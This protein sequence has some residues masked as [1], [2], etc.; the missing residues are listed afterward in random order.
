MIYDNSQSLATPI[1][2]FVIA[3]ADMYYSEQNRRIV[4]VQD[5]PESGFHIWGE[6]PDIGSV[7][8]VNLCELVLEYALTCRA[9]GDLSVAQYNMGAFAQKL[10]QALANYLIDRIPDELENACVC[11]MECVIESMKVGFA[12]EQV[13][14]ELRFVL[15]ECPLHETAIRTGFTGEDLA[16]Y[17]IQVLCETLVQAFDPRLSISIPLEEDV[18][19]VFTITL[20]VYA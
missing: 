6:I 5:D 15:E 16:H 1:G 18:Q 11:A 14:G 10:G 19:H 17:G 3:S 20:P 2:S 9:L 8:S 4:Y 12:M 7:S 13:S